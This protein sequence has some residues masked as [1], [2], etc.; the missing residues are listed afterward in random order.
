M[1]TL[2]PGAVLLVCLLAACGDETGVEAV[3]DP[4]HPLAGRTLVVTEVTEDGQ[5]RPLVA[6]SEARFVFEVDTM[7]MS[8][9]CNILSGGY[10]L[11]GDRLVLGQLGGTEM[12]CPED[13]MAQ[14]AWLAGLFAEPVTLQED[15]LALVS[16]S[17]VLRLA[18]R[19]QVSPD[20]ALRGTRW[21]LDGLV[22]GEVVSSVPAGA[23]ASLRI[24]R[25]GRAAVW[26]GC[27]SGSGR[28]EVGE[29]TLHWES[30]VTTLKGCTG[31]AGEV[32]R[33]VVEVLQDR[34]TYEIVERQLT[35]TRGERALVFR[36]G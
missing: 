6:G 14:D 18:D 16:G 13:L 23:E 9:G 22:D 2:W 33:T 4:P 36:A 15:P 20:V 12:G 34:T 26:T 3:R 29:G 28:V 21:L 24:D 1:R 10:E 32:E 35:I 11:E 27:N 19:E 31:P 30:L 5:P 17:V 7:R 25:R 8:A